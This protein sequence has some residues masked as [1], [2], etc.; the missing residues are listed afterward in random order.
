ADSGGSFSTSSNHFRQTCSS[1]AAIGDETKSP[2]FWS[3]AA[4]SQLA[5]RAAGTEPPIT[6]P[7]NRGPAIATVAGDPTSSSVRSTSSGLAPWAGKAS[8]S[9]ERRARASAVGATP[10]CSS[11]CRYRAAVPAASFSSSSTQLFLGADIFLQAADHFIRGVVERARRGVLRRGVGGPEH[12]MGLG[13]HQE[14]GAV[15]A[16]KTSGRHGTRLVRRIGEHGNYGIRG[17]GGL[18]GF[19]FLRHWRRSRGRIQRGKLRFESGSDVV[20]EHDVGCLAIGYHLQDVLP[21]ESNGQK[22][23]HAMRHRHDI[24][25]TGAGKVRGARERAAAG[26]KEKKPRH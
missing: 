8:S 19:V 26:Y 2:A 5:A 1:V 11:V 25:I 22:L 10:R 14:N 12:L 23:V 13:V 6:K 3:H 21:G 17:L 20:R 16:G 4:A 24:D 15:R 9:S 7:K 18:G